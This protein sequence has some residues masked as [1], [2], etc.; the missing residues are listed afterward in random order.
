MGM[1]LSFTKHKR[2]KVLGKVPFFIEAANEKTKNYDIFVLNNMN[3]SVFKPFKRK[4]HLAAV[5]TIILPITAKH[6]KE[7][8][9]KNEVDF[10]NLK[11]LWKKQ[12][13]QS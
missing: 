6:G 11:F 13:K 2:F 8:C 1:Y 10:K 3:F 4:L 5:V 9:I 7:Y 12:L